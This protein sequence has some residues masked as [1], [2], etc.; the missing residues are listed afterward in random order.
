MIGA[1]LSGMANGGVAQMQRRDRQEDMAMR[2][3]AKPRSMATGM[4]SDPV[5]EDLPPHARAFLNA[6]AKGESRGRYDVRFTPK[7]GATFDPSQGHPRIFEKGPHGP[8]SAAGRYQFTATTWDDV[9]GGSD[10]SPGRQDEQAWNLAQA[11][12]KATRGGDLNEV[13]QRDGLNR[14]TISALAPTWAAFN[15][16]PDQWIGEYQSSLARYT[17]PQS[18]PTPRAMPAPKPTPAMRLGSWAKTFYQSRRTS[19]V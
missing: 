16:T 14:D 5:N 7:G 18:S 15:N 10:F 13:L 9:G 2:R 12:Y 4:S 6:V 17:Q 1:F 3:E 19:G 11:R 8:S